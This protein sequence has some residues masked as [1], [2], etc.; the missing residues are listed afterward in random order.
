MLLAI[1]VGNTQ[2]A[3]GVF[4]GQKLLHQWRTSTIRTATLDEL[5]A[6]H[7][8]M[9]RLRGASLGDVDHIVVASVVPSLT[10]GYRDL[11]QRYMDAPALVIG[12]GVKTGMPI[13]IDNPREVGA[14]RIVNA[15]AAYSQFGAACIVV[16]FG[17]ATNFD[18][19]SAAG[20][21]VGGA[22][23]PGIEVSMEALA[24]R[25]ARLLRIEL[26]DPGAA[27]G[28][29]T[30][31]ALQ[32]GILYGTVAMVD[33]MCERLKA[34]LNP[35]AVVVATGGLSGLIVPLSRQIEEYE[36]TLTLDGLRMIHDMNTA[37]GRGR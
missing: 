15:V 37:P 24:G 23:A 10:T 9:L 31:G 4:Q 14:D 29:S 33:G 30:V 34:E 8:A 18:C 20:E 27:I 32:S 7:D 21:Y 22:I 35:A 5:A 12:P 3:A 36:P 25:A 28:R 13:T 1:D 19:V 16:D 6:E 26:V 11:S 2:T 17:T